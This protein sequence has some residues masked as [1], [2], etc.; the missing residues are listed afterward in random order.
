MHLLE[1]DYD[2]MLTHYAFTVDI[3]HRRC[4]RAPFGAE[5][6]RPSMWQP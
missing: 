3:D 2:A 5:E 1:S 4:L 6:R